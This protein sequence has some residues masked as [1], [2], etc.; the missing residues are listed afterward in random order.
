M[1]N[2]LLTYIKEGTDYFA[3][4][5]SEQSGSAEYHLLRVKRKDQEL[6]IANEVTF[7][8]LKDIPQSLKK[9]RPLFLVINSDKILTKILE[10][11]V[12]VDPKALVNLAFP[13]LDFETFYYELAQFP[14]KTVISISNKSYIDG[15]LDKFSAMGIDVIDFS[16]GICSV[17]GI[18]GHIRKNSIYTSRS[19]LKLDGN[20]VIAQLALASEL[21]LKNNIKSLEVSNSTM[22]GFASI[23]RYISGRKKIRNFESTASVGLKEF[24][25]K[26]IFSLLL[27]SFLTIVLGALLLNF[28]I[29]MYYFNAMEKLQTTSTSN[30]SGVEVLK[31]LKENTKNKEQI[32]EALGYA[33]NSKSSF[34]MDQIAVN[35]PST[36]LL[37]EIRYQP[38]E[39]PIRTSKQV[40]V[41]RDRIT[42]SGTS[43]DSEEFSK[44]IQQLEHLSWV[45][46][47]ETMDYDYSKNNVSDFSIKINL[48]E[49]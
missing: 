14:G 49:Q 13:N 19:E 45:E 37:E 17:E 44:W 15:Y 9:N 22:L 20:A 18:T 25:N 33:A 10:S 16:L 39:K 47:V 43:V 41:I 48:G 11:E 34:F 27:K 29:F 26:R 46:T 38:L 5:I 23:V 31:Q 12:G 42:V 1:L 3:L 28:M 30:L 6:F 4:E 40:E 35:M 36:M 24:R 32:I 8:E 7:T 21:T 2:Q